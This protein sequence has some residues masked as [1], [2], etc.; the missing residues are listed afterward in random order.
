MLD[1][2]GRSINYL[3]ISITDLCNLRCRYCMT[4]KGVI[5]KEFEEIL[6][7]EEI[8]KITKEFVKL[9]INKIR[10]TGGEPLVR[11]GILKLIREIGSLKE[12]KDFAMTTNGTM[13]K[14][15]AKELK[16]A[17]LNRVN[18]SLDTLNP[19][20]YSHITRGGDIKDVLEGIEEA[21][22]VGLTPIKLNVVLIKGFNE[23]EIEDFVNLTRDENIDVR[24]IELMPIGQVCQWSLNRYLSN[25]TVLEKCS[26][27]ERIESTDKSSPAVYYKLK[28]GKGRVGLINP[29]SCKFCSNCNRMRLTADG[30]IKACLHSDEEIDIMKYLRQDI[31]ISGILKNIIKDKPKEHN[32]E[33]GSYIKRNM[34]AIGG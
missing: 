34:M 2:Y 21:K 1:S 6:T 33:D 7:L 31:D 8:E 20:K 16:N 11:K 30:K 4:D 23:D 29:I 10:I 32:L 19:K 26:Y 3:R 15:Y 28:N 17:G 13:L 25:N 24:F 18:I 12:V 27:L 9:G 5:K 14:K 22:K